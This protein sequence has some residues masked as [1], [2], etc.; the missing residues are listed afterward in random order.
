MFPPE[1]ATRELEEATAL[2]GLSSTY[3]LSHIHAHAHTYMASYM[4]SLQ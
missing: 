2:L 4:K 1:E 3:P